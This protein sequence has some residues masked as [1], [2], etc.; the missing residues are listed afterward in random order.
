MRHCGEGVR[1]QVQNGAV[2]ETHKQHLLLLVELGVK[3]FV[4]DVLVFEI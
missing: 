4:L 1:G 3:P 2:Y